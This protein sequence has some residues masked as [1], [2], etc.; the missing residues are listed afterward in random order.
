[1][2]EDHV[3]DQAFAAPGTSCRDWA[4]NCLGVKGVDRA[5]RRLVFFDEDHGFGNATVAGCANF[6][7]ACYDRM[8]NHECVAFVRARRASVPW[9]WTGLTAEC[10]K[11]CLAM[12][13]RYFFV[14]FVDGKAARKEAS[15]KKAQKKKAQPVQAV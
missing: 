4:D 15:K 11:L 5:A 7:R 3:A 12:L 6:V 13:L 9:T 2:V 8:V 1:M 14:V 10:L